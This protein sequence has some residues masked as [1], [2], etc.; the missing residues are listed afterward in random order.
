[1]QGSMSDTHDSAMEDT[2][3]EERPTA[4][5]TP[6][7]NETSS[8]EDTSAAQEAVTTGK[9]T[10][11]RRSTRVVPKM[12]SKV[13]GGPPKKVLT[14]AITQDKAAQL[15]KILRSKTPEPKIAKPSLTPEE[16][17]EDIILMGIQ[18]A[19]TSK[20][21]TLLQIESKKSF[22]SLSGHT[23]STANANNDRLLGTSNAR[24]EAKL[25]QPGMSSHCLRTRTK[26]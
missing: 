9:L 2:I 23:T 24:A 18:S 4:G 26:F 20:P 13:T 11:L 12:L 16:I 25:P 10:V 15:E 21:K 22:Q 5:V 8:V 6:N 1:M 7:V 17:E 3:M 19:T 14:K